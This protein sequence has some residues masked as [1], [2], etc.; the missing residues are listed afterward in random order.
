MPASKKTKVRAAIVGAGIG[1]AHAEG[2]VADPRA[3]LVA[4]CDK[5]GARAEQFAKDFNVPEIYTDHKEMLKKSKLD[6][7]S[8]GTPN[9]FHVP[10]ALDCL[11]A[12]LNV[13]CEK[14]MSVTAKEALKIKAWRDSQKKP[15]LFVMA[16]CQRFRNEAKYVK[17][18]VDSGEFG[19]IYFARTGWLRR[20]GIPGYG[21]WFTTKALAGGGA[22]IDIGVHALDLTWYLMGKPTPVSAVGVSFD[23]FGGQGKG[24]GGWGTHVTGGTFDV[25]DNTFGMIRFANGAAIQLE[26]TWASFV[27]R[28][29][30]VFELFGEKAGCTLDPFRLFTEKDGVQQDVTPH[31][32]PS[33]SWIAAEVRAFVDCLL[34]GKTPVATEEDGI[35]L[36]KMLDAIYESAAKGKEVVIKPI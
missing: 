8:I 15:P 16:M 22:L 17:Q 33:G 20:T 24:L 18:M 31:I 23:K 4:I 34:E 25:D 35:W 21:G 5:D 19:D 26:A 6:C 7:V 32:P 9:A 3:E 2:Y 30:G 10:I 29:Q 14:P 11:E 12:G 28:E 1:R 13:L 27:E 36:M